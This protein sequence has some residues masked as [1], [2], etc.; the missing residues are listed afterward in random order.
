MRQLLFLL[1]KEFRQIFRNKSI[2]AIIFV[3]P[4]MQLI[5]LPLAASY[6]IKNI[7]LSVVDHDHSSF[8]RELIQKIT[9]CHSERN[10]ERIKILKL[11]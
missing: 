3:A 10:E 7:N 6:E 2:L 9:F 1:K 4:M 5:I 8:S 11:Q